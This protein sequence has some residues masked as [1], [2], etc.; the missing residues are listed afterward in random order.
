[1][2]Q[3]PPRNQIPRHGLKEK[4]DI[5]RDSPEVT[6]RDDLRTAFSGNE[7][8]GP[9]ANKKTRTGADSH[10]KDRRLDPRSGKTPIR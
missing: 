3:V 4:G 5:R 9:A 8:H 1:M 2:P 7:N 6:P 10:L